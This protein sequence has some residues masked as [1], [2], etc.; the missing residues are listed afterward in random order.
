MEQL[1]DQMV[2]EK[3]IK[4]NIFTANSYIYTLPIIMLILAILCTILWI[5]VLNE[6]E[7]VLIWYDA[8][9]YEFI[10]ERLR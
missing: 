3:L 1:T 8:N 7:T 6:K 5:V 9:E 10:G 2:L 4:E